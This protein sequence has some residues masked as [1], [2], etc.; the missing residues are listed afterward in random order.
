MLGLGYYSTVKNH[1]S[2]KMSRKLNMK[3]NNNLISNATLALALAACFSSPAF[4]VEPFKVKDIRVEGL[5]R[6]EAGTVFATLPFQIGDTYDDEKATLSIRNLIALGLFKD[7]KITNNGDVLVVLVEERPTISG[8]TFSGNKEFEKEFL[9]KILTDVGVLDGRP[10]DKAVIDKAEQEIKRLYLS[11]SFFTTSLQ[12]TASP[13]DRNRVNLTFAITEG[14]V[15]KINSIKIEGNKAFSESRLLDQ[16]NSDTGGW[17]SWYTKSNRYSK[18]KFAAD[19]ESLRSFYLSNG[20][21]EYRAEPPEI[22]ASA[23]QSAIDI[24]LKI[25]EGT[26]FV[27]SAVKLD[28]NYLGKE[29][30]FKSLV[31]IEVGKNFNVEK[32]SATTKAFGNTF[33]SFGYAFAKVEAIPSL[34]RQKGLVSIILKAE[35]GVRAYVRKINIA[36][37]SRTRDEVIRREFRQFESSWYDGDKIK[38]S[39]DRVDR[40]GFFTDVQIDTDEVP[41]APDQVDVNLAV[42]EKPTGNLS[43]GAGYS[44]ADKVSFQAGIK[45]E[46]VFGSGNYLGLE[47]NTSKTN[48]TVV[49][50]SVDPYFTVDGISRTLDVYYKTTAPSTN[51]SSDYS[52][53]NKGLGTRFGVPFSENDTV[54]FGIAYDGT[55]IIPGTNLPNSY[56][57]YAKQ[58]GASSYGIPISV[59]W[60]RDSRDSALVPNSGSYQRLFTEASS[61]GDSKYVKAVGQY[62]L[63]VPLSKKFT[64]AVNTEVNWGKGL[65]GQPYP[66][67]K[68]VK[69]GGLGTVRGFESNTLGPIEAGTGLYLGGPKK[70]N[71]NAE[72]YV[73]FPGAGA[74]RTLRLYGFMDVGNVYGE[75]DPYK[76][77]ELRSS[78]GIGVSWISPLG[79]LRLSYAKAIKKFDTDKLQKIQFQ[80]GT[81]F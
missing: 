37:N 5:Q 50:T 40:L 71:L 41:G 9:T 35:P 66:V 48:R 1:A 18:T 72:L 49:I 70:L 16:F 6:V 25:S 4:A 11:R 54:F 27:V 38:T 63:Y 39:R 12:T 53:V 76:L 17:L 58:F 45:Q 8:I 26:P 2:Y 7:V 33:G 30:E 36:G 51:L 52:L 29:E 31:E 46:N 3:I 28:G 59:G 65:S 44:S 56:A 32:L 80:I 75:N 55:E 79:P 67:F 78:V 62:Q 74:D 19:L 77:D 73:P 57:A 47:L 13:I 24:T 23:D 42:T 14:E 10:F 21:I 43:L 60:S 20:Y 61:L 69:G 81:T 15:A 34:D 68:N 64:F 22:V